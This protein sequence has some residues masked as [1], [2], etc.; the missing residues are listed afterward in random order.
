MRKLLKASLA[1]VHSRALVVLV[2]QCAPER[3]TNTCLI[4]D[5]E[6]FRSVCWHERQLA[7]ISWNRTGSHVVETTPLSS[8]ERPSVIAPVF[9]STMKR[10]PVGILAPTRTL[11]LGSLMIWLTIAKPRPVPRPFVEKYG[12]NN[13]SLS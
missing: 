5:D 6:N 12:R 10:T 1:R 3:L 7:G 4:V 13:F 8:R 9:S 2:R 11:P